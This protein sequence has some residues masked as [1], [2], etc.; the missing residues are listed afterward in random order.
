MNDILFFKE[1]LNQLP[2]DER[3]HSID[4]LRNI[5]DFFDENIL[6]AA[7]GIDDGGRADFLYDI[8]MKPL[9]T[10]TDE[11]AEEIGYESSKERWN[12]LIDEKF[13]VEASTTYDDTPPF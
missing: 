6:F 7:F 12:R 13:P 8:F 3:K 2:V 11:V 5:Y 4:L 10:A 9:L 1:Q